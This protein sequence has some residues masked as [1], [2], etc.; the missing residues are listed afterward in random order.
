AMRA[1]SARLSPIGSPAAPPELMRGRAR[2]EAASAAASTARVG[3]VLGM[4]EHVTER[5]EALQMRD[6]NDMAIHQTTRRRTAG[7]PWVTRHARRACPAP[8]SLRRRTPTG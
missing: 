1:A 7:G 5:G 2:T 3:R 8:Q 4:A 6:D